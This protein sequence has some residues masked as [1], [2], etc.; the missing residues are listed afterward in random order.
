MCFPQ[1]KKKTE[2]QVDQAEQKKLQWIDL[3][4]NVHSD[5]LNF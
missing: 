1:K 5:L 3:A 2:T 4:K